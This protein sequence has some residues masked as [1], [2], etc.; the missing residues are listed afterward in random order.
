MGATEAEFSPPCP[1]T[2]GQSGHSLGILICHNPGLMP[3]FSSPDPSVL[4][5]GPSARHSEWGSPLPSR[6]PDHLLTLKLGDITLV[7]P[8]PVIL[9]LIPKVSLWPPTISLSPSILL[10]DSSPSSS[11]SWLTP[12]PQ[13]CTLGSPIPEQPNAPSSA[14]LQR[15]LPPAP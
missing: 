11:S 1:Q 13:H 10:W 3:T 8:T 9:V 2:R 14:S 7:G 12:S 5:Q 15:Y 4:T 6:V